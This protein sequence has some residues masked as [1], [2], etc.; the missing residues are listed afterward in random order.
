[1]GRHTSKQVVAWLLTWLAVSR[2]AVSY[3][4]YAPRVNTTS[5]TIVGHQAPDRPDTYE[6]LGIKYG[7]AP[8]GELR[9][10]PPERYTAP[11]HAF[12]NAST[13]VS[14]IAHHWSISS[15]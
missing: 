13:W 15:D 4:A 6:Y 11:A 12:H 5:G 1:M 9:F 10:A 7:K 8:V 2:G 3:A 14:S